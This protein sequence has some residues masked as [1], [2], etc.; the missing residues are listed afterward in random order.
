MFNS[1]LKTIKTFGNILA[2][3]TNNIK[4]RF[5]HIN[6][7]KQ[8]VIVIA[9]KRNVNKPFNKSVYSWWNIWFVN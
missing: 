6:V 4:Q 1:Y 7:L 2:T 3:K 9:Y 5:K 8:N